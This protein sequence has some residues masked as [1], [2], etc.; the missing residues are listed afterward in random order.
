[1]SLRLLYDKDV[2]VL[3]LFTGEEGVTSSSLIGLEEVVVDLADDEGNQVV[4]LEVM[5]ASKY[6]PLGRRGYDADAD[7]LTLG[8]TA[9]DPAHMTKNGDI[10][11]YWQET[12]NEPEPFMDP[13]GVTLKRASKYLNTAGS[14]CPEVGT[15]A[16]ALPSS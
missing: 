14:V 4:G 11:T 12:P 10:V 8:V 9:N 5:G 13:I 15:D 1:M 6:L 16:M 3:R 2:D 7:T